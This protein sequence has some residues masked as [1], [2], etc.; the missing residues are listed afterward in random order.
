MLA[1]NDELTT[2]TGVICADNGNVAFAIDRGTFCEGNGFTG[3]ENGGFITPV[4]IGIAVEF[5]KGEVD[6]D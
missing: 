4:V 6:E 3:A 1:P 2:F 5:M